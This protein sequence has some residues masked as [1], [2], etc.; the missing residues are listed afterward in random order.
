MT[1]FSQAAEDLCGSSVSTLAEMPRRS[2]GTSPSPAPPPPPQAASVSASIALA[3]PAS[4]DLIFIGYASLIFLYRSEFARTG[5]RR[6]NKSKD[7]PAD[8]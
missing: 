5:A 4:R 6:A 1:M 2:V 3:A 8:K 7:L